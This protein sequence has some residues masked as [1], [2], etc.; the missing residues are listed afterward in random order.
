[1]WHISQTILHFIE[2]TANNSKIRH[3]SVCVCLSA[4]LCL[5]ASACLCVCLPVSV[6]PPLPVCLSVCLFVSA[7][8]PACLPACLCRSVWMSVRS[9]APQI[10]PQAAGDPTLRPRFQPF[11]SGQDPPALSPCLPPRRERRRPGG[12]PACRLCVTTCGRPASMVKT[13]V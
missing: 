4:C 1:M 12:A 10:S 7:C 13:H 2:E 5:S 9:A 8:L 3:L 11:A 6:C